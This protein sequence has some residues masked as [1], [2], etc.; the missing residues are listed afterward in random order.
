MERVHGLCASE[1]DH[2]GGAG[3][4]VEVVLLRSRQAG[5]CSAP[6]RGTDAGAGAGAGGAVTVNA[7]MTCR[8]RWPGP[9]WFPSA[10]I[11]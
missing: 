6:D 8:Q 1:D 5:M 11:G 4:G 3:G 7:D 2:P 10:T 9:D